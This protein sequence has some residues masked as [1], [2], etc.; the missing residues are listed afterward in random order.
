MNNE[1]IRRFSWQLGLL[2]VFWG[3]S[4]STLIIQQTHLPPAPLDL[5][6][7]FNLEHFRPNP[8][9][10]HPWEYNPWND[11]ETLIEA[12]T[13][14]IGLLYGFFRLINIWRICREDD[15]ESLWADFFAL[16][17]SL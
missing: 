11:R 13:V 15:Q 5:I 2:I 1:N 14:W 10:Y 12:M 3:A 8:W 7:K 9:T 4:F 17:E 16:C 6:E